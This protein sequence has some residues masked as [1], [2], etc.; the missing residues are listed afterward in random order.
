MIVV[1]WFHFS[2]L[3]W[4][5]GAWAPLGIFFVLS[6]FLIT[7]MLASESQRTGD[8]SLKN[9]Y[10]LRAVRLLPPLLLTITLL[11]IYALFVYV[12]DA[13]N[14]LWADAA[15]ALF[16]FADY[17]SA[18]GHEPPAPFLSQCWSLAVE[19][20]FYLVW[21]VLLV[22]SLKFGSR[23][24]AYAIATIGVVACTANRMIIVLTHHWNIQ[25]A[26]KVYYSFDTRAD[27]LFLGCLLGLIATGGHLN[28]WPPWAKR[29]L[30]VSALVS[31]VILI[32][33]ILN[34]SIVERQMYLI[35]LPVSE[36]TS[37]ILIIYFVIR[38]HGWGTRAIGVSA[39]VLLGNMSY[40]VYLIHWPLYIAI[41]SDTV[42][43][44]FWTINA[45]RIAILVPL[46]V[47]SWYLMERP[48]MRWRRR[49]ELASTTLGVSAA[50]SGAPSESGDGER[51][52]K[53]PPNMG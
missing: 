38:P 22:V 33:I 1:V 4:P 19:E 46:V 29:A 50:D 31:A 23:R 35:W 11:G 21:V 16:N 7:T 3:S 27:A 45:V 32:W 17:R 53:Q 30:S 14:R 10:S 12:R 13:A 24:A 36:I 40:S 39:L 5:Q 42:P 41:N 28:G 43:W 47:G 25:L 44:S 15:A 9:F 49:R 34:T 8:I 26:G 48:L 18:Y 52:Q 20:Q 6:G 2:G 37:A 51:T